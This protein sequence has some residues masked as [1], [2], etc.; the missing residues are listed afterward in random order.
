MTKIYNFML[1]LLS[2]LLLSPHILA[3]EETKIEDTK[4]YDVE[5]I[6]FKNEKVPKSHEINLPTPSATIEPGT[7]NLSSAKGIKL[8]AKKRFTP[9]YKN[10]FRLR[11]EADHIVQSSRYQLLKHI[12]WRQPGL[13]AKMS[14]PVWIKGGAI[15]GSGY[16]SIDQTNSVISLQDNK[17]KRSKGLYELEGLITI[18]L[19]RYLHTKAELVLR[20]PAGPDSLMQPTEQT[21]NYSTDSAQDKLLDRQLDGKLLLNFELKEKRR[22]RSRHLH[23]L[24]H[25]QFGML[26]LITP[27]EKPAEQIE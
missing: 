16:S 7:I 24:D 14:L 25:P 9:L 27:F 5:I 1:V 6:V 19:S 13:E 3:L 2:A 12:A 18:I 8:A 11:Q 15:Y 20:K 21:A 22:M 26:V 10:E 17:I 4:Y 23:Y